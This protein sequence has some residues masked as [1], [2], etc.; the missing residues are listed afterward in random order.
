MVGISGGP[1][2]VALL[3]I[4]RCLQQGWQLTLTAVHCNYGL[5][6]VESEEDQKSVEAFC[7]ELGVP[8]HIRQVRCGTGGRKVSLQAE[9]RDLRYGILREIAAQ[10]GA[11]RIAIGHTAN[12]Q[13]ETVLL[14]ILRGAGMTGLSGMPAFRENTIVRPLYDIQRKDIL[15][16]LRATGL[17]FREDSSNLRPQYLR[18]RVRSEVIP[19]LNRLVPTSVDALCHLA[20]ICREDDRYLD[21]QADSLST[22]AVQRRSD[23][24]WVIDR[25]FLLE[26]PRALQRRCI[27]NLFRQNDSQLHS[28]SV[29]TVDCI[30]SLIPHRSS[31]LRLDLKQGRIVV[32]E[33]HLRF[34]PLRAGASAHSGK[35][36]VQCR[37]LLP[38]PGEL[39]WSS[40]GQRLQVQQ[41]VRTQVYAPLGMDRILVDADR[42]TQPLIVRN[43]M[44]GDRFYPCGMGGHSKKLQDFFTD[45]KIPS[46]V[47]S[48]IPLVVAPEGILWVVGY[49]QDDRWIPTAET[50][51]Y[52]V[53]RS[54]NVLL[55]KGTD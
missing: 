11:D 3:S 39:I 50:E 23:G 35:E 48:R 24:G 7:H 15:L 18:N 52:L 8:L 49:R 51:R 25:G 41:Q 38:V 21:Q 20:D 40:T 55:K 30:L 43:W 42:V 10:C 46:A 5:R 44:P 6:G 16:Y 14:W 19:I 13:A 36:H 22:S 27:R 37:E 4:L 53:F 26:L 47:R 29:R 28:P 12:D 17:S 34:V 32:S 1:D 33:H 2:S 31:A 9:A 54:D 45:L